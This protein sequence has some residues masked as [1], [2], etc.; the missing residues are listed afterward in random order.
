MYWKS[1]TS[2]PALKA[3]RMIIIISSYSIDIV[4]MSN[5]P[6][7]VGSGVHEKHQNVEEPD[8]GKTFMSGF[9]DQQVGRPA[10]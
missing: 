6:M 2:F 4:T 8:E 10:C 1:T 9:E 3:A 7:M 5:L